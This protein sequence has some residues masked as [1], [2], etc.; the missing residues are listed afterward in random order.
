MLERL[1]MARD[2]SRTI[3]HVDMD[4]VGGARWAVLHSLPPI[5][6]ARHPT[7]MPRMRRPLRRLRQFYAAVHELEDPQLRA[8][9][10]AVGN[11]AMLTTANYVARKFGVRSAM[12]GYI[13][14]KLCPQIILIPPDF[15]KY[16]AASEKVRDV[17]ALYDPNFTTMSLDEAYLDITD[18][19]AA[20][21]PP[22]TA[23]DVV[24]ELRERICQATGGLT[25]S[26]GIAPNRMLAKICTDI[27]KPN[28]QFQLPP[29]RAGILDF[30]KPLRVRRINGIG[31]VTERLLGALGIERCE[32]LLEHRT[33]LYR[34]FSPASFEFFLCVAL[35]IGSTEPAE[36]DRVRRSIGHEFTFAPISDPATLQCKCRELSE[37]TAAELVSHGLCGR[38]VNVK[39]K[40]A[41]FA[42]F[43]RA[44]SLDRYTDDVDKISTHA[45]RLLAIELERHP[46]IELRLLGVR[47][48]QLCDREDAARAPRERQVPITYF[49]PSLRGDAP[50]RVHHAL[51]SCDPAPGGAG[52]PISDAQ[53]GT[54]L[55]TDPAPA[56]DATLPPLPATSL[57]ARR[58]RQ[59]GADRSAMVDGTRERPI[60]RFCPVCQHHLLLGS[61]AALETH[62]D[63]CLSEQEARDRA[64]H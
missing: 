55:R 9:P 28:G 43:T 51:A 7:L 25:S 45:S 58:S 14:K 42:V 60:R 32:Q 2:L 18:H 63:M 53:T 39:L 29:D 54:C 64:E 23:T 56:R 35:G 10:M 46:G 59:H 26:A 37:K 22:R 57:P 48:S 1:E 3:V 11:D 31:K 4:A 6:R 20:L 33:E 30:M 5:H 27:N 16:R 21:N 8:V 17:L 44:H 12:P 24:C 38:C 49:L 52:R 34:L 40:T 15:S 61:L 41:D 36:S 62:V 13:A 47:M 50:P 19:L